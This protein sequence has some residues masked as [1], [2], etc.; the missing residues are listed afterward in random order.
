[1]SS[2]INKFIQDNGVG[3]GVATGLLVIFGY[4]TTFSEDFV[5]KSDFKN[6]KIYLDDKFDQREK[7]DVMRHLDIKE[8]FTK[9][10]NKLETLEERVTNCEI[11]QGNAKRR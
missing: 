4:L 3:I 7:H 2:R 11:N 1:M 9:F 6:F 5:G 8:D 10:E